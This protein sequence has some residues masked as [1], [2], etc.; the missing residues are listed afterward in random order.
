M[1]FKQID[2]IIRGTKT[3]TRRIVKE[4]EFAVH[5]KYPNGVYSSRM[6]IG[7]VKKWYPIDK[8]DT[9]TLKWQVGRDYAVS[10]GRGKPGVWWR[11]ATTHYPPLWTE[12]FIDELGWHPLRIRITAIRQEYVQDISEEDAIAEGIRI[13]RFVGDYGAPPDM[14]L[15]SYE[16]YADLWNSINTRKGTRWQDNPL[17]WV[18]EFQVVK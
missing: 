15:L 7:E 1:F 5:T 9:A 17:C 18:L 3:Q 6:V 14:G 16:A 2:E 13:M 11:E 12:F 10:P 8:P 4:G